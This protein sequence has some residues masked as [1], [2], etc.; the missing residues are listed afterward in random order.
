MPEV[1]NANFKKQLSLLELCNGHGRFRICNGTKARLLKWVVAVAN[2]QEI[3]RKK[4][5]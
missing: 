2:N 4:I 3:Q 1:K 5:V